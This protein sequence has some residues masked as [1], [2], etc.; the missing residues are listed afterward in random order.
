[1]P[2]FERLSMVVSLTLIGLALYFVIDLPAQRVA[3]NFLGAPVAVTVSARLLMVLLLGGLAFTGAG[4]V[5][6]SHP[7]RRV[8]YTSPFWVNA[9]LIVILATLTLARLGGAAAWAAG[10]LATGALL[11]VVLLA[12]YRLVQ[13][14]G[15]GA[16]LARLWS[17]GV[18]Y[19]LML[20]YA[21]LIF[22]SPM[23][24]V[25][26]LLSVAAIGWLLAASVFQSG[27]PPALRVGL[28]SFLVA[29]GLGQLAWVFTFWPVGPTGAA[30][31]TLLVFYGLCGAVATA[32]QGT[33]LWRVS[34]EY[35]F[36]AA[37]GLAMVLALGGNAV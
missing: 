10:L 4:A 16:T 13:A 31:L 12:E 23:G 15:P 6:H 27:E 17:Q 20:A 14:A 30:V 25:W 24:V 29:L 5:V 36:V 37:A 34:L 9:T 21:V 18:S 1:M 33:F 11:W 8:G 35:G 28:L 26:R 7:G 2:V 32:A 19:A 22:Q 3:L